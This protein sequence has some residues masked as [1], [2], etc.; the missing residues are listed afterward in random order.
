[1]RT[2]T[3][4]ATARMDADPDAV[5]ALL[6]D[7]DRLPEWNLAIEAV[8]ERPAVL[9]AGSRWIVVMHPPRLPRWRSRSTVLELDRDRRR[10]AHRT[11]NDDGNPSYLIWS[12]EVDPAGL[13][14]E[15]RVRWEAHLLTPVRR[16][17]ASR[18]R[19][20]QLDREVQTSLAALRRHLTTNS[21]RS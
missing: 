10:F 9:E 20:P 7:I 5:F 12:W 15:V 21:T 18:I 2:F 1:M 16:F 11:V 8:A 13:G 3:G 4:T 14:S 19:R 6:T 17:L